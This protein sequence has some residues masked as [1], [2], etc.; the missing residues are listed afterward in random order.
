ML[1][2]DNFWLFVTTTVL[3]TI[4]PGPTSIYIVS[5]SIAQG[6]KAG[7][8]SSL[9]INSAAIIHILAAVLGLSAII[10]A[11]ALAFKILKYAGALFLIYLGVKALVDRRN[12]FN[13]EAE[14]PETWAGWKIYLQG[15]LTDLLNPKP[16]IF[17]LAYF[18]Q[19]I[20]QTSEAKLAQFALL[21]LTYIVVG[22]IWEMTL[23]LFA[24]RITMT[25][26]NNELLA[27]WLKRIMGG[28]FIGLGL[29]LAVEEI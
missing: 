1:G 10:A 17:F 14:I 19:F 2:I 15:L 9:G 12:P 24:T 26:R 22:I 23:V 11:S 21:G 3:L 7:I 18:P 5:R 16:A 25:V 29:R 8:L 6:K 20:D 28:I 4:T 13:P 27:V